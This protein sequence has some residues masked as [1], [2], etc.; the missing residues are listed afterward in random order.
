MAEYLFSNFRKYIKHA[1]LQETAL[2]ERPVPNNLAKVYPKKL[3]NFIKDSLSKQ[4][5]IRE[6]EED[7]NMEKIQK[8]VVNI[9]EPLS[10]IWM[11]LNSLKDSTPTKVDFDGLTQAVEQVIILVGRATHSITYHR[12][13]KI[14]NA[15]L[16]ETRKAT[17]NVEENE[18]LLKIDDYGRISKVI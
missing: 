4:K 2:D 11:G 16:K 18:E 6:V 9:M 14:L 7:K 13:M 5:K 1:K 8:R 15:L 10:W 3:D 17:H 12:Q